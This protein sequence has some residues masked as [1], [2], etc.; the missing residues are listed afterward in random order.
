MGLYSLSNG[1]VSVAVDASDGMNVISM[2]YKGQE[3]VECDL[4]K[5]RAGRTYAIPILFPTPNR[6]RNDCY[7]FDG[8]LVKTHRHGFAR[9]SDF[10]VVCAD[11]SSIL[12]SCSYPRHEGFPYDIDFSVRISLSDST[13]KWDFCIVNRGERPFPFGLALHPYFR[14]D[15][16]RAVSSSHEKAMLM[17]GEMLPTGETV[18]SDYST[19]VMIDDLDVDSVFL[20]DESIE[21]KLLGD[22]FSLSIT[23]SEEFNHVVIFTEKSSRTIC[24]EPQTCST[25]FVNLHNKGYKKEANMLVVSGKESRRLSIEMRFA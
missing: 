3:V 14:K 19:P 11:S 10:E 25:D 2:K 12:G 4:E 1:I 5:K 9:K 18:D 15:L 13:V 7:L 16:F 21:S 22:D 6:T 20:A 17:D 24:V 23:A 8:L